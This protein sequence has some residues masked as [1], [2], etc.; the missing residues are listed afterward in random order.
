MATSFFFSSHIPLK[1]YKQ[2]IMVRQLSWIEQQ[3]LAANIY[4]IN[5]NR[6]G[7]RSAP[8]E[9]EDVEN[10]LNDETLTDNAD[11]NDVPS[12]KN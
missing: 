5:Y 10:P 4:Y 6:Y 3:P 11:G 2:S 9:T 7:D 12:S 8:R 1:S